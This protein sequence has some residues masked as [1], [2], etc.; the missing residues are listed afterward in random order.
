MPQDLKSHDDYRQ[1]VGKYDT[2]LFDCDGVIWEGDNVIGKA[3]EA[4]Q[5]LREEG[6]RIFFVTNNATKSRMAN[7]EKFDKLGIECKEEEVFTSASASASYLKSVR[8]FPENK[9][10]YVLGEKGLEEE[11]D[12]VGIRR[13]GGTSEEDNVFIDLMDFSSITS[14]PEVGAVVCGLDM[15]MNY[16]KYARAFKYLRE[17][18]DCL[19]LATNLDSTFPT[20]GTVH[21]GAGAT[22]A[23]LSCALGREPLV[24]GK[25]EPPMLET[26]VAKYNLDKSRMIMV[27]DRLNTDIAF[28]QN[29]GIDT[30]MVLT[31][32]DRR[33][34]FERKDA[35]TKPTYVIEAL[36][37][38]SSLGG[39]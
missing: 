15:H 16:K 31:G 34:G 39:Q 13:C 38:L 35:P 19:F 22:V 11:L 21:P 28:G 9:K 27:G 23:P 8:K 37:D 25:P 24:I 17:N 20:H 10:V 36:G 3:K 5:Y 1:L 7:K 14:D 29:G 12:S 32:V 4:L 6:K 26:I 30:M 2:F 18:E 33:E